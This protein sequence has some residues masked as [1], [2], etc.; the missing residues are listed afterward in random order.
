MSGGHLPPCVFSKCHASPLAI[1]IL[2][3]PHGMSHLTPHLTPHPH[4]STSHTPHTLSHFRGRDFDKEWKDNKNDA[5]AMKGR[6]EDLEDAIRKNNNCSATGTGAAGGGGAQQE[7]IPLQQPVVN[8][9]SDGSVATTDGRSGGTANCSAVAA[10]V[11]SADVA[12]AEGGGSGAA[13][14]PTN[15]GGRRLTERVGAVVASGTGS[16]VVSAWLAARDAATCRHAATELML[17]PLQLMQEED[18]S[19]VTPAWLSSSFSLSSSMEV[20]EFGREDGQQFEEETGEGFEGF[21]G[22]DEDED[23]E[24]D[25]A[26]SAG[27]GVGASRRLSQASLGGFIGFDVGCWYCYYGKG[28]CHGRAWGS[29]KR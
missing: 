1:H 8:Q 12:A 11:N 27:G 24:A 14:L 19:V 28:G 20:S 23:A 13:A 5:D 25:A 6:V 18:S 15:G 2:H 17:R 9:V 3:L 29:C 26:M 22:F 7:L 4:T 10:G 21:E 16:V